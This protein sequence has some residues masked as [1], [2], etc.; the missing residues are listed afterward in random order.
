[1]PWRLSIC[2]TLLCM[3]V[4][5]TTLYKPSNKTG[6]PLSPVEKK[7]MFCEVAKQLITCVVLYSQSPEPANECIPND[8]FREHLSYTVCPCSCATLPSYKTLS[9]KPLIK[10]SSGIASM[11]T[12]RIHQSTS[13]MASAFHLPPLTPSPPTP[14]KKIATI[15]MLLIWIGNASSGFEIQS[16]FVTLF[17]NATSCSWRWTFRH[18]ILVP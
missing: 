15:F 1:M 7:K 10:T 3:P 5:T 2:Q 14:P 12:L 6:L 8:I 16:V 11:S 4:L 13:N 9:R 18:C 17:K